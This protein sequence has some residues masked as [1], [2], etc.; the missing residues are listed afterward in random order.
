MFG[1]EKL[2]QQQEKDRA[3]E[4][5]AREVELKEF[6]ARELPEDL[7]DETYSETSSEMS[8]LAEDHAPRPAAVLTHQ[9]KLEGI[10]A[11]QQPDS[12]PRF[13]D[14]QFFHSGR[15]QV[16]STPSVAKEAWAPDQLLSPLSVSLEG[17]LQPL[18]GEEL[19]ELMRL[20]ILNE[21]RSGEIRTLQEQ[22]Q[23]LQTQ[24]GT[25]VKQ[26][27]IEYRQQM[28]ELADQLIA[29]R[30]VSS[31]R[32]TQESH[33]SHLQQQLMKSEK[34]CEGLREENMRMSEELQSALVHLDNCKSQL[35]TLC[36]ADVLE[37]LRDQHVSLIQQSDILH[38][39]E[40]V[41]VKEETDSL[42]A[43]YQGTIRRMDKEM[44]QQNGEY[45]SE[46]GRLE[47]ELE[48]SGRLSDQ[49]RKEVDESELVSQVQELE[50]R[51][52]DLHDENKQLELMLASL[53]T[54]CSEAEVQKERVAR[55]RDSVSQE[56]RDKLVEAEVEMKNGLEKCRSACLLLHEESCNRL[57]EKSAQ[58]QQLNKEMH[59]REV[60][61]LSEEIT[62]LKQQQANKEGTVSQQEQLAM[63]EMHEREVNRLS[64]EITNLKQLL[65]N[66]EGTV[67]QQEQLAMREM[68]EREVN[69]LSE[70]I[71]NLKQLLANKEGT[72]SQQ[73][74]LAMREMHEREVNRLSE[75]ITNLKQLL[76]NKEGTVSQQEQLAMREM[77]EREVNRLSEEIT[78]LKQLLA[79]K[80]GTLSLQEQLALREMHEREVN[81]LSEEI[82]NLKQLLA[83]KE[84]T[85]SQQ[86]QLAM[87]EM[88]EREVNR[89]SEEITNLKQLLANKEGTVSQQEQLALREMHEKEVN[90]LSE[91]I[92]NLK[93]QQANKEG[94]VSQQE[95]LAL[96]E[97]HE[98]EVNRLSEEITNLK[99][100]QAN[101]EGT[102]SLQEQLVLRE[103]H[104]REV[105]RLSEEIN[106]LKQLLANKEGT[107]SLQE[108]LALREMHERE[109]NRLSE[110]INNL[111]QLLANKEGTVSLQEQLALR[112]MH[113][114]EVNKLSE[115][116]TNLKQ[117]LANKEGTVSLQEQLALREMHEREVN[118]LSEEI[119]NL[120]QLLANRE[121]TV[122]L[123]EQ[124]A[125]R[126]MHEREVNRLS[127]EITNLKQQ[128]ANKEGTVSLQE[129]LALREMH[130]REVN[131][132]SEEITNLKQLLANKE[133]TL[134]L[135]EQLALREM[136][137]RE[138]NRLSEEITNLK[139]LLANKEGTVSQQEQLALRE[140]HEREVNRLSEEITNL[141]LQQA[142]KEGTVSLQ[143]Q[144]ALREIHEREVNRLSDEITNLKHQL[145][146]REESVSALQAVLTKRVGTIEK[147]EREL[148]DREFVTQSNAQKAGCIRDA[149]EREV[150]NAEVHRS[151]LYVDQ[152]TGRS[153]RDDTSI[154]KYK[155]EISQLR[156][157]IAKLET[158]FSNAISNQRASQERDIRALSEERNDIY[159]STLETIRCAFRE[160][161]SSPGIHEVMPGHFDL[162]L[163]EFY[164]SPHGTPALEFASLLREYLQEALLSLLR[165][166]CSETNANSESTS[167]I[168]QAVSLALEHAKRQYMKSF[169]ELKSSLTAKYTEKI[170][171][172][173]EG[174]EHE[175]ESLT[176]KLEESRETSLQL[177][178]IIKE[179]E[180]TAESDKRRLKECELTADNV[181]RTLSD[182]L[183]HLQEQLMYAETAHRKSVQELSQRF[184]RSVA[185]RRDQACQTDSSDKR[186]RELFER[187]LTDLQ[188]ET[189]GVVNKK[190]AIIEEARRQETENARRMLDHNDQ[191]LRRCRQVI[192]AGKR[193]AI[194]DFHSSI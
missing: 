142:N 74:Q 144:L 18:S 147:L 97:M 180:L 40:L 17:P 58:E 126:E 30:E 106:N 101:K 141:K 3:E 91:E 156:E 115:E 63:R 67:S 29:E 56:M 68:L 123:Q 53:R 93:Q 108:Q 116:I 114:R 64:E 161:L 139:Q 4:E 103:M 7:L 174:W 89:L 102:V 44:S 130:E 49:L 158:E 178:R 136:H 96:R 173:S 16:A 66:K 192:N 154:V 148:A 104:E 86:E 71:T 83:N 185:E 22:L 31:Q 179:C 54:R 153:M 184:A 27:H 39:D 1:L 135:Q 146:T 98:K 194:Q 121:G 55:E 112:E 11:R 138:V 176:G 140:M 105:N 5:R 59:E 149:A 160:A 122:S 125:L 2:E 169:S 162:P 47:Q 143:E 72:V 172:L 170:A 175:R 12:Q 193:G 120:K 28:Q 87:R 48:K 159:A 15:L 95:Q 191:F 35:E 124:L 76:A 118:R 92:T 183:T 70:E 52:R 14:E 42:T 133:G 32:E 6:L 150:G 81:R 189:E 107:V 109:V 127:E 164:P 51:E 84:G 57:R 128:Q 171:G 82:T 19:E 10:P 117:L 134:S 182:Q 45:L 69:R 62:N 177:K 168:Q 34:M 190:L 99:Q 129:Q 33:V 77:H 9:L 79:N 21:A 36:R 152:Q 90:R 61:R 100:Q 23:Q 188:R 24:H 145:S 88:H 8:G 157:H 110:E 75:E 113:E 111:K 78:N 186:Y 155:R 26:L 131:R 119:T 187:L 137:E 73:E 151:A 80:E 165:P 181:K 43:S 132:L 37:R 41:R 20:R 60:K 94:T 25:Q 167:K 163:L 65:A 38:R 85:V 46:I 166:V 13:S 50:S